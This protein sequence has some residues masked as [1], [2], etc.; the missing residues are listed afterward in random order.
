MQPLHRLAI[1]TALIVVVAPLSADR[2]YAQPPK[3]KPK[4]DP[5]PAAEKK[6]ERK[7]A[8]RVAPLVIETDLACTLTVDGDDQGELPANGTKK[9]ELSMG[10]HVLRAVS[11]EDSSVVWRKVVDVNS[12]AR[13]AAVIELAPLLQQRRA[14]DEAREKEQRQQQA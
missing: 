4:A 7:P 13:R 8:P 12:E 6:P 2:L 1:G 3:P 14:A 9:L 10:E 5:P 11:K